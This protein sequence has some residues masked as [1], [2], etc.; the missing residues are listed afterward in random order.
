MFS[1]VVYNACKLLSYLE[2]CVTKTIYLRSIPLGWQSLK[3]TRKLF[4]EIFVKNSFF[5]FFF[6]WL[7]DQLVLRST[8]TRF[9]AL[10]LKHDPIEEKQL[11]TFTQGIGNGL[12][13]LVTT[14][15]YFSFVKTILMILKLVHGEN[16]E[17]KSC[18]CT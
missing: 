5:F 7:D 18:D 10:T 13:W 14:N 12:G 8:Q 6:L 2:I 3:N 17:I 16:W 11:K 15:W 1:S 9:L 4:R